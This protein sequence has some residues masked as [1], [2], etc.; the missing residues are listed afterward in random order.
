MP[1]YAVIPSYLK[2][3]P[4]WV[5]WR[6]EKRNGEKTKIPYNPET[7]HEAKSNDENTWTDFDSALADIDDYD[8]LGFQ[9]RGTNL[10]G[11]DFDGVRRNGQIDQ[12]V[13]HIL[14]L[15][16]PQMYVEITPSGTGLRA[17]VVYD[18]PLP[19]GKR[20]FDAKMKGVKKYGIE[21]YSGRE[22][23]RYLTITGDHLRGESIPSVDD[24][25]V[26]YFL[27]S[28]FSDDRFKRMWL[29]DPSDYENDDSRLD[30][31]LLGYLIR[32][33]DG[34]T[35]EALRFF[36][37]S[38]PGHREKWVNRDDYQERTLLKAA[39]RLAKSDGMDSDERQPLEFKKPAAELTTKSAYEYILG[40]LPDSNQFEGWFPLGSP[41]LIGGSSGSG[42]TTFML[43]LCVTQAA[44]NTFYGHPVFC[45]PYLVLMLD[46]GKLSH[47]RTMRRLGFEMNQV[48]I[49]FLNP[50]LD[51][52][53]SQEVLNRI[54]EADPTPQLVFI[55]GIDM[56]VSD[57]NKIDIVA[58]FLREIQD[59]ATHFHC[60][61]VGSTG[62]PKTKPR[63]GYTAKRDTIFGSAVW[64]RMAE[65]VVTI[66]FPNGDDTADQ[67]MISVLPRNAKS[68][69]FE[70]EFQKGRLV[71]PPPQPKEEKPI[72][73]TKEEK[74]KYVEEEA[75]EFIQNYMIE[76]YPEPVKGSDLE[77]QAITVK[78]FGKNAFTNA[79][80]KLAKR[81]FIIGTR[82]SNR[83]SLWEL[84][85][86]AKKE[87]EI[88]RALDS[89]SSCM[90]E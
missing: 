11:F 14:D 51:D 59:I 31:A 55:E 44:G 18:N 45:R 33:F 35:D 66:Q 1:N 67:R 10:V 2:F 53:A 80:A 29:G 77:F 86:Q 41:S 68:E 27:I 63:E 28:K 34:N 12:Y 16:P 69:I 76:R 26:P 47:E 24:L 61:I 72:K 65:T 9:L 38:V 6:N 20:K 74:E 7:G 49:Q 81:E 75:E 58:P 57:P 56:L 36:N 8:G 42:K 52:D 83:E 84:S 22:G 5:T 13:I 43:D 30:L 73:Q 82:A 3:L 37:L 79:R 78:G 62:A 87:I 40:P 39:T 64:S 85:S 15:L 19:P 17:F 54:E 50:V 46:R 60:A 23:G 25:S 32:A 89:A 90:N 88:G 21:I 4:N 71:I 70:T 48:P